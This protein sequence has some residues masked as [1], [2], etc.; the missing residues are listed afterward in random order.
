MTG[1]NFTT[2]RKTPPKVRLLPYHRN[3]ERRELFSLILFKEMAP[4]SLRNTFLF[5]KIGKSLFKRF[6]SPRGRERI[7]KDKFPR[8]N[9]L[10]KETSRPRI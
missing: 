8:A 9:V 4:R 7:S 6:M 1:G 5:C 10:K 2:W 3:W